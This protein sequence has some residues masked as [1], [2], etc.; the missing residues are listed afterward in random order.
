MTTHAELAARLLREAAGIF[1]TMTWPDQEIK[2]RVET[3]SR[4]F[5]RV[6]DLVD[7]DP[8]GEVAAIEIESP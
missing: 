4:L 3:F 8:T 2:D 7:V 5:D 1:R 6:A